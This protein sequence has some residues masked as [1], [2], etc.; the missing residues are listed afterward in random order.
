MVNRDLGKDFHTL[1]HVNFQQIIG[2]IRINQQTSRQPTDVS[3]QFS[4]CFHLQR[5]QTKAGCFAIIPRTDPCMVP[6]PFMYGIFTYIFLH[7]VDFVC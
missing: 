1:I 3:E 4:M 5:P 2:Y 7:L 6:I